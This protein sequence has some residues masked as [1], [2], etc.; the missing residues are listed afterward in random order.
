MNDDGKNFRFTD[1]DRQVLEDIA[2]A[3]GCLDTKTIRQRRFPADTT[4]E[5][6]L[7][8]IRL[9]RSHHLLWAVRTSMTFGVSPVGRLPLVLGLTPKAADLLEELTGTRPNVGA[10]SLSSHHLEHRL[11]MSQLRLIVNDGCAKESLSHPLWIGEYDPRPGIRPAANL[12]LSQRYR[13]CHQY[14]VGSEQLT[15]W[16]DA[17]CLVGVPFQS[18]THQVLI[19]WEYDRSTERLA[20]VKAKFLAYQRFTGT[21]DHLRLFPGIDE[22]LVRI[23]VVT[24]SEERWRNIAEAI[25]GF[26]ISASVRFGVRSA[27]RMESMFREPIWFTA[28]GQPKA[29]LKTE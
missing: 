5:A 27:I 6:C 3:G 18:T 28:E 11:G 14:A 24:Q 21:N 1:R 2:L 19:L 22:M 7:R 20:Q 25:K 17:A 8:R 23:F 10:Q 9:L 16:P 4:G 15:C 29:I 12:K 13:L 26:P